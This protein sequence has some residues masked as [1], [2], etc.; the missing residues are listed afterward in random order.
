M[1]NFSKLIITDA[2]KQ[3]LNLKLGSEE[4]LIFTEMVMSE[5][6]YGIATLEKLTELDEVRQRTNIRKMSR[7]D[8][9]IGPVT[10]C[11]NFFNQCSDSIGEFIYPAGLYFYSPAFNVVLFCRKNP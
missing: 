10:Q 9:V 7:I 8:N 1:A 4:E 11:F 6:N 2:G 5:Q 3:L